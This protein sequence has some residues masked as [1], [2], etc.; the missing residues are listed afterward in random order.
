MVA[1][2]PV[3]AQGVYRTQPRTSTYARAT[4]TYSQLPKAGFGRLAGV[5]GRSGR[6]GLPPARL[7]SFVKTAGSYAEMIYGDEGGNLE[8]GTRAINRASVLPPIQEFTQENRIN[9]GIRGE[10]DRGL[11]TGHGSYLPNAWGG[12]EYMRKAEP[13]SQSGARVNYPQYDVQPALSMQETNSP[14]F[15]FTFP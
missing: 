5:Y 11:T 15:G 2:E 7:D 1:Q 6:N 10:R 12:D 8:N 9:N 14:R 13:F 4:H 3:G